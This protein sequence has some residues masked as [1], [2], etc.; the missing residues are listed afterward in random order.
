M[1]ENLSNRIY[2]VRGRDQVVCPCC[3]CVLKIIGSRLRKYI[4]GAGE[5]I[6]L[7]IRR[8]RCRKCGRVH[9]ELPDILV[10]YKRYDSSSIESALTDTV[11][12]AVSAEQSTFYRWKIWYDSLI[13]H[14]LC[15]LRFIYNKI[16]IGY[17]ESKLITEKNSKEL[18]RIRYFERDSP[19]WLSLFVCPLVNSNL[20]VHTRSAF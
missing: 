2:F 16:G 8:L 17:S 6:T 14:F 5:V 7:N 10:P 11:K 13:T 12:T 19:G 20:Y 9:H 15:C 1:I 4:N 3:G 18:K